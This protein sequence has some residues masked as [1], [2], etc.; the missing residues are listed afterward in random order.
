M[1]A[2]IARIFAGLT[3]A[4][5]QRDVT[6]VKF[7]KSLASF[8]AG[9]GAR[10]PRGQMRLNFLSAVAVPSLCMGSLL[11]LAA[12]SK[13]ND[14]DTGAN[15]AAAATT[16]PVK[17]GKACDMVT[18]AEM[19]A[20]LGGPVIA[21]AGGN[22]RP[23]S[24]TECIY[25][26]A[27]GSNPANAELPDGS[28]TP[29]AEL[30]VDWGGGDVQ[31]LDTA[32]GLANTAAPVGAVDSLTGLGDR[33]YKVTAEQVFISTHGDLMMIRFLRKTGEVNAKARRIYETAKGRM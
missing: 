13:P 24:A 16:A 23:P 3:L 25:S 9:A 30:E 5:G 12:C 2:T 18:A 27:D 4:A 28:A 8:D 6:E 20:I 11:L 14:A 33:A 7:N 31:V 19:S 26:P 29:Y 22:E 17:H 15:A 1:M 32:T 10:G 21:A